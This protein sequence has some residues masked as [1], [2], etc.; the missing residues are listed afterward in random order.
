MSPGSCELGPGS[1]VNCTQASQ[2][3]SMQKEFS[4]MGKIWQKLFLEPHSTLMAV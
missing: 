4:K 3:N 1:K 2:A